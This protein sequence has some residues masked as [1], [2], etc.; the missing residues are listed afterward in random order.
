MSLRLRLTLWYTGLLAM[1]LILIGSMVFSRV[2][3]SVMGSI[4]GELQK[5]GEQVVRLVSVSAQVN[6]IP[7]PLLPFINATLEDPEL[8]VQVRDN[9]R[10]VLFRSSNLARAVIELPEPYYQQAMHGL[11]GYY[12]L[13]KQ[14]PNDLRVYFAPIVVNG[15]TVG[16]VQVAR[17]LQPQQ[18]VLEQLNKNLLL[19]FAVVLSLAAGGGY[20]LTGVALHP[21]KEATDT[22][23]A[24]TR[25]GNLSRRVPVRKAR[26]DEIGALI[27]TFNEMLDRLEALFEKQRRFSADIS[28]ELRSPL[29]TI[30]GNLS[31]LRRAENLPEEERDDMLTEIR[32]EAER[33]HRLIS[34]LLLLSQAES[35]RHPLHLELVEL[36]HIMMQ[37]FRMAQRRAG[38]KLDIQLVHLD[39]AR[40]MGDADRLRQVLDNLIN[41]AIRYTPEGGKIVLSLI[42]EDVWAVIRVADTGQGIAPEDLPHIFDRFYRADKARTRAAGGAGLGL[43]IVKWLVEAHHGQ[44]FV[45]STLG[46]GATFDIHLPLAEPCSEDEG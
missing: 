16:I 45:E 2:H 24:I 20:W 3:A 4:D 21:I 1:L 13:S 26:N 29:T 23:L 36:D 31:L 32:S 17:N 46:E 38:E 41:N 8:Y 18:E 42:C 44:I 33:M 35:G 40:V 22:A 12:T 15:E 14:R 43:S 39:R 27:N 7:D 25:T 5:K 11:A 37:A 30:L 19:L 6:G 28:H 34:D 9:T 10:R